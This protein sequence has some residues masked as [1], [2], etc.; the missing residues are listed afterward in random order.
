MCTLLILQDLEVMEIVYKIPPEIMSDIAKEFTY[1]II[2][3]NK[4]NLI[5]LYNEF[6]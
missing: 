6:G 2:V 1:Q 3:C 5:S 4:A